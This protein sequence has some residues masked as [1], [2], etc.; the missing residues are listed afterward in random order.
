MSTAVL[1]NKKTGA[2]ASQV[3]DPARTA[4]IQEWAKAQLTDEQGVISKTHVVVVPQFIKKGQKWVPTD[5]V[6]TEHANGKTGYML[7]MGAFQASSS[8]NIG[9]LRWSASNNHNTTAGSGNLSSAI[10]PGNLEWLA[11]FQAGAIMDGR[12][13]THYQVGPTNPANEK[14]DLHYPSAQARELDIP[15]C[16]IQ[17]NPIYSVK[18]WEED[19]TK[20]KPQ[21]IQI[22]NMAQIN[23]AIA[24]SAGKTA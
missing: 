19:I 21:A 17:G 7:V 14:Q 20:P 4:A 23:A 15:A 5:N 3:Q 8:S 9:N 13:D 11:D 2:K 16:D 24:A 6:V 22:A 18:I 1:N 12:I 10:V